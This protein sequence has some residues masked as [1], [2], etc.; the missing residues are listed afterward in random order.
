M[1][2][3]RFTPTKGNRIE[4]SRV[5]TSRSR[6]FDL[7]KLYSTLDKDQIEMLTYISLLNKKMSSGLLD[8]T[9]TACRVIAFASIVNVLK[10]VC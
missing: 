4:F 1:L 2:F 9:D 6:R 8:S 3:N 10:Y 7:V 5:N